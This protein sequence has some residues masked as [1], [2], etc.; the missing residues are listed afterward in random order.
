MGRVSQA[1]FAIPCRSRYGIVSELWLCAIVGAARGRLRAAPLL[2]LGQDNVMDLDVSIGVLPKIGEHSFSVDEML[3]S[4]L[5]SR[6][7]DLVTVNLRGVERVVGL[8][9]LFVDL[10]KCARARVADE[11]LEDWLQDADGL[12]HGR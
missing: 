8:S 6:G 3:H 10:P 2:F 1:G 9:E 4:E 7:G 5:L 11:L 12:R